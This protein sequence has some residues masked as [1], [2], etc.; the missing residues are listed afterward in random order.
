MQWDEEKMRR[1]R[2]MEV[3]QQAVAA[4]VDGVM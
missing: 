4:A 2:L 1:M 3:Q